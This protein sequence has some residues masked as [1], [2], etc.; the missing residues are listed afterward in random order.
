MITLLLWKSMATV[1]YFF[2]HSWAFRLEYD[3]AKRELILNS[4]KW[5][6]QPVKFLKE[7][8][9]LLFAL[10]EF[11][12]IPLIGIV[13]PMSIILSDAYGL[14]KVGFF[15]V[16]VSMGLNCLASFALVVDLS[17][18]FNGSEAAITFGA[19]KDLETK[20]RK[21]NKTQK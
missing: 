6:K 9:L 16:M 4:F 19:V 7:N 15:P 14:R 12:L 5:T 17:T 8:N 3:V 20:I 1:Q 21:G 2:Q 11:I 10:T 18:L 13:F